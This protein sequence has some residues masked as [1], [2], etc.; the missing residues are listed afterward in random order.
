MLPNNE[1]KNESEKLKV[2]L[3]QD[4]GP[5]LEVEVEVEVEATKLEIN[6]V[7]ELQLGFPELESFLLVVEL[8]E[9]KIEESQTFL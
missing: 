2:E 4:T 5:K 7:P 8:K 3:E 9:L 6:K 1:T